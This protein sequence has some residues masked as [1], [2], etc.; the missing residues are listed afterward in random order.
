M[1]MGGGHDPKSARTANAF[2]AAIFLALLLK[3]IDK[4]LLGL[5]KPFL[6]AEL[7]WSAWQFGLI[8]GVS[9]LVGALCLPLAGWA[10]DMFSLRR[11]LGGAV[12]IWSFATLAQAWIGGFSSLFA[13][14][15]AL[16]A[17]EAFG[18]PAA[19]RGVTHFLPPDK[20]PGALA[21][22]NMAGSAAAIVAPIM[23]AVL[24]QWFGWRSAAV[25][26]GLAGF[27]WAIWWWRMPIPSRWM[28]DRDAGGAAPPMRHP[29]A[30]PIIAAK[31]L[32]DQL[33]WVALFW[34]PDF[35][36]SFAVEPGGAWGGMI[37]YCYALAALGSL[38]AARLLRVGVAPFVAGLVACVTLPFAPLAEGVWMASTLAGLALLAH[39]IVSTRIFL[40]ICDDRFRAATGRLA[41]RAALAGHLLAFASLTAVGAALDLGIG[42]PQIFVALTI[43]YLIALLFLR[44]GLI[45][46]TIE[47]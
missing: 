4:Q 34:L 8:A 17:S 40:A 24:A 25:V 39:Q 5:F 43:V 47:G 2:I 30:M 42:Y 35:I 45:R 9:Q 16:S 37:A 22:I 21:V 44:A 15:V 13:V 46:M 10:V 12:G 14:R 38:A 33:W 1:A 32:S 19:L 31:A 36:Q 11:T 28:G 18:T 27:G 23:V 3:N 6:D 29:A 26:A 20:R 41:G 7:G